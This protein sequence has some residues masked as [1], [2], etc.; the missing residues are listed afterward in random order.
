VD[1]CLS[2]YLRSFGIEDPPVYAVGTQLGADLAREHED[3][4]QVWAVLF[5]EH[6][7]RS[8]T[9][10]DEV[11][12]TYFHQAPLFRLSEPSGDRLQD[13]T[14]MLETLLKLLPAEAQFD[15][16]LALADIHVLTEAFDQAAWELQM[17]A[18]VKPPGPQ[19]SRDLAERYAELDHLSHPED[20]QIQHPL[21]HSLGDVIALLG[22]GIGSTNVQAGD[23]VHISLYWEALAGMDRDYTAFVHIVG[24]D[25]RLRAQ[26]DRLLGQVSRGGYLT[27]TWRV[28]ETVREDFELVL[29]PDTPPG[30]YVIKTGIYYWRTGER[31]PVRDE[32]GWTA[33]EGSIVLESIVVTG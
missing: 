10:M 31:L 3:R 24:S 19:A 2:Y 14:S 29:P 23:T 12:V 4:G 1:F 28:E 25:D 33:T 27:S 13:A 17:A 18:G 7:P 6:G 9:R 5:Y 8:W 32:G 16:H 11:V 21:W 30:E 20:A 15:V 26:E 22:Y